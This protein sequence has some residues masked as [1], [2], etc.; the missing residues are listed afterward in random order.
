MLL[1]QRRR[2]RPNETSNLM[3]SG[4]RSQCTSQSSG[5]MWWYL[6]LSH[7]T[8]L[9]TAW[10]PSRSRQIHSSEAGTPT[11]QSQSQS[12]T[13]QSRDI[14]RHQR[15]R[16]HKRSGLPTDRRMFFIHRS[17]LEQYDNFLMR[18]EPSF[19]AAKRL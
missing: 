16:R 15:L 3:W 7:T 14:C 19:C 6:R 17:D 8:A 9:S 10:S 5:D 11:V 2:E 4:T 1:R 12:P 13:V 18:R